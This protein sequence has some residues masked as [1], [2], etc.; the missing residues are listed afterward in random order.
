MNRE[1]DLVCICSGFC[2]ARLETYRRVFQTSNHSRTYI[3]IHTYMYTYIYIFVLSTR[4]TL[5]PPRRNNRRVKKKPLESK[6]E[7]ML[8]DFEVGEVERSNVCIPQHAGGSAN[9]IY[10]YIRVYLGIRYTMFVK[11]SACVKVLHSY[12]V[13]R[14]NN[15][16]AAPRIYA[17]E[18]NDRP[19]S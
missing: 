1:S 3:P 17:L 12:A 9:R 8:L 10:I 14:M 11:D 2:A 6:R 13:P 5:S 18:L 15:S 16:F 7:T 19:R 4:W